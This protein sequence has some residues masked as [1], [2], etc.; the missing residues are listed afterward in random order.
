MEERGIQERRIEVMAYVLI[1]VVGVPLFALIFTGTVYFLGLFWD[2]FQI[3]GGSFK[4]VYVKFLIVAAVYLLLSVLGIGGII[5]LGIMAL[6]YKFTFD[7]GWVE[8]LVLGILGGAV[9]WGLF[10]VVLM[11]L[12]GMGLLGA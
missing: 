8:A 6:C 1:F 5:G 3:S 7:A 12:A 9:A 4:E 11:A 10:I 2:R